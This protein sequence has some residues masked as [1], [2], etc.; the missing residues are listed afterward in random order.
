[1][2]LL[3]L[4]VPNG[5]F[6][7]FATVVV[8]LLLL[9]RPPKQIVIAFV[10]GLCV[11]GA[12]Y[13]HYGQSR[14]SSS[15][16]DTPI[17]AVGRIDSFVETRQ[18]VGDT[19]YR[20]FDL[21]IHRSI[22]GG[23]GNGEKVRAFVSDMSE[24]PPLEL[25]DLITAEIQL[26][27]V[28][29]L[30]NRGKLPE[31]IDSLA[32]GTIAAG[33]VLQVKH[34]E[35]TPSLL[36]DLRV[37]LTRRITEL[38]RDPMSERILQGLFLG[39]KDALSESDW[40]LLREF[41][42]VHVLIVSGVHVSLVAL[43]VQ[44]WLSLPKRLGISPNIAGAGVI[45]ALGVCAAATLYVQLTG[46]SLP[47]Q[48]ALFMLCMN[49]LMRIFLW[50]VSPLSSVVVSAAILITI[51]PWSG[52]T[53]GFWLSVLLTGVIL[54]ELD[55]TVQR[56]VYSWLRLTIILT[57]VSSVLSVVFFQQFSLIALLGNLLIAP[58][59]TLLILPLGLLC[60][61]MAAIFGG[62]GGI[63][64]INLAGLVNKLLL[65]L[66]SVVA[67]ESGNHLVLAPVHV[68]I[69]IIAAVVSLPVLTQSGLK[70]R[71]ATGL[72]L[73]L[74]LMGSS[75]MSLTTEVL[76]ADVGQGTM[77]V[78]TQGGF[79]MLYDT[80]GVRGSGDAIAAREVIPW[81]KSRGIRQV[82]LLV[83]SHRDL[84]HAGGLEA[85][86]G[87]FQVVHHWGFN[88]E[89]CSAGRVLQPSQVLSVTVMMGTGQE[90]TDSNADSCVVLVEAHG[91]TMLFPGDIPLS[92]EL[93]LLA[94]GDLPEHVD[95]L[96]AAHH[97]SATSSSQTFIDRLDP[98]HTVLTTKR[99]NRFNH[100]SG[101]VTNRLK[102]SESKVWDTAKQGA[103]TIFASTRNDLSVRGMRSDYSPYWTA[104]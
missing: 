29:S 90:L 13:C 89:P 70:K 88:G 11:S 72:I 10:S 17:F 87:H 58:V 83:V 12:H 46:A 66:E 92:G 95:L 19:T 78:L 20:T 96:I 94:R 26:R 15:C 52:L 85:I 40:S 43:W 97:G 75:S 98:E 49:L 65:I 35:A 104:L 60:L 36:T 3:A 67:Y 77:I 99:A 76:V 18:G 42:I 102:S 28:G 31:N 82:D 9:I 47:A 68:G 59:F 103:V 41:G 91:K 22:R 51:N 73:P 79:T 84:D 57:A 53:A 50:R 7:L 63:L 4:G 37:H 25:G 6:W 5:A 62:Q 48:R 14:L 38:A 71:T 100:P 27:P 81:L 101:S 45:S 86:L 23:C 64:L 1:M 61:L 2:C 93:E 54:V 8:A 24:R 44:W 80:G 55:R 74:C 34:V 21:I 56:P 33:T 32:S 39:R 16:F 30:W 69:W